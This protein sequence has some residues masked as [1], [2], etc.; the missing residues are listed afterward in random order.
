MQLSVNPPAGQ[1]QNILAMTAGWCALLVAS[2]QPKLRAGR[3]LFSLVILG[4][5]SLIL[6]SGCAVR[7][8]MVPVADGTLAAIPLP[9]APVN[10][11]VVISADGAGDFRRCSSQLRQVACE[12]GLPVRVIT[13][14]WSHG[15]ARVVA[16]QS[17]QANLQCQ[18]LRLAEVVRQFHQENPT[19]TID[20]MGHSAGCMVA[21]TALE[22]LPPGLVEHCLLLSPSHTNCYDLRPAL[23]N[24]GKGIH[25][26]YSCE[27][28]IYL[29]LAMCFMEPTC[30]EC[31]RAAGRTGYL[32]CIQTP[33]DVALY[34]KLYQRG[35]TPCD[36]ATGNRGGHFGN[37]EPAFIRQA[38]LP[39]LLP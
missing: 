1:G 5:F 27:D 36:R 9:Q 22:N 23:A 16:D 14:V 31:S 18:G 37:Y 28:R 13:F 2:R 19:T 17:D 33:K 7:H 10:Q 6:M 4:S 12:D 30:P 3:S 35:W 26:F 24:I 8:E 25:V 21:L 20:L 11:I 29:D 32:V 34:A 38:V 15:Y 39:V